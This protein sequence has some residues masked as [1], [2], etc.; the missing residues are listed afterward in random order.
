MSGGKE[1]KREKKSNNK[2]NHQDREERKNIIKMNE[3]GNAAYYA[4]VFHNASALEL[5]WR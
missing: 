1:S 3:P 4:T 2:E 5:Q